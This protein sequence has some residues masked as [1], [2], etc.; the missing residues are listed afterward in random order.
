[1][2]TAPAPQSRIAHL[3]TID[4]DVRVLVYS[5]L[6]VPRDVQVAGHWWH[7]EPHSVGTCA[8]AEHNVPGRVN[9]IGVHAIMEWPRD[10][11]TGALI[12]DGG[13]G[14]RNVGAGGRLLARNVAKHICSPE[15]MGPMGFII[16]YGTPEE[17]EAQKA[18]ADSFA[19]DGQLEKVN[20][21]IA[22]WE[23]GVAVLRRDHPGAQAP[24]QPPR[25]KAAYAYR[26]SYRGKGSA[27]MR[28]RAAHVCDFCGFETSDQNTMGTHYA[29]EHPG[30]KKPP[31]SVAEPASPVVLPPTVPSA[32]VVEA[33]EN[34]TVRALQAQVAQLQKMLEKVLG[35]PHDASEDEQGEDVNLGP[36]SFE[37]DP[38][39]DGT[40]GGGGAEVLPSVAD[41]EAE[42][43]RTQLAEAFKLKGPE[44]LERAER[45]KVSLTIEEREGLTAG[46][47]AVV[48]AVGAKIE[49]A[50]QAARET[51]A[52]RR[53][54]RSPAAVE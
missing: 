53:Q 40:G 32:A 18:E 52:G 25:I 46:N 23:H 14:S 51:R 9:N 50:H 6:H 38:A 28:T 36:G 3:Q 24:Q 7:F 30:M 16:L 42:T 12:T 44:L 20:E 26:R 35:A 19:I 43:L 41:P 17:R 39:L 37:A 31:A 5:P 54:P 33:Q 11:M 21:T 34:A 15:S 4:D 22:T 29:T 47:E 13:P 8:C 10:E 27:A 48:T 2:S 45:L 1:M 49:A